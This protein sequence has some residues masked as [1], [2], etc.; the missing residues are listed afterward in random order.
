MKVIQFFIVVAI[1]A[2]ILYALIMASLKVADK[3]AVVECRK[4]NTQA[5]ITHAYNPIN[6]TGFFVTDDEHRMCEQVGITLNAFIK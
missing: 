4:L 6:D 5:Q 1:G 2:A 3:S